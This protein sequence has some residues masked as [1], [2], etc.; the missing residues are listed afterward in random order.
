MRCD[1]NCLITAESP[2]PFGEKRSDHMGPQLPRKEEFGLD[3]MS[4]CGVRK[5]CES[6]G[7]L[8]NG[9]SLGV[10]RKG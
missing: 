3:P 10:G 5:E 7:V 2:G 9:M 4:T 6:V 1:K 8:E